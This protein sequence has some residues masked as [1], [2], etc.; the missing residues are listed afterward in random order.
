[1]LAA[2]ARKKGATTKTPSAVITNI[3]SQV[4]VRTTR[5]P[6]AFGLPGSKLPKAEAAW[7]SGKDFTLT[8]AERFELVNFVDGKMTVTEIRNALSAEFRPIRQRE[9]KRYLEDLIKVG[10]LKWK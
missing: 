5:G 7:Y 2:L 4:P 8:G 1:V 10:V 9:V 3:D 6:L